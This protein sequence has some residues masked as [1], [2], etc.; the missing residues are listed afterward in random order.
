[1]MTAS[2]YAHF[3]PPA[4]TVAEQNQTG[5][6]QLVDEEGNPRTVQTPAQP[7]NGQN[8]QGRSNQEN[9][10]EGYH[11]GGPGITG[12]PQGTGQDKLGRLGRL[13]Q[14]HHL[15]DAGTLGDD[16]RLISV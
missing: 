6:K 13:H 12:T 10:E 9:G 2:L 7:V 8:G 1:M 14:G 15:Q 11:R 4:R 5:A 16:L 3:L